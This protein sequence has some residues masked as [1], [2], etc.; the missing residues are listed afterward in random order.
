MHR[1][2]R[3]LVSCPPPS[4]KHAAHRTSIP[5]STLLLHYAHSHLVLSPPCSH[6][7]PAVTG[8]RPLFA[9]TFRGM[10]DEHASFTAA[11]TTTL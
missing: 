8:A 10:R 5:S 6:C 1:P 4:R 7:S 9:C 11:I 2:S 3:L